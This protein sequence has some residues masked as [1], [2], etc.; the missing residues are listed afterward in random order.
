MAACKLLSGCDTVEVEITPGFDLPA[1]FII[2]AVGPRRD[3]SG[4]QLSF[5]YLRALDL[6]VSK[7]L[8][9]VHSPC[10]STGIFGFDKAATADIALGAVSSWLRHRG[11]YSSIVSI[12]YLINQ[13]DDEQLYVAQCRN[14]FPRA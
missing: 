11:S 7:G 6:A 3:Q 5:C 9:S 10:L 12:V 13:D 4:T 2:Q 8:R 14:V 1:R